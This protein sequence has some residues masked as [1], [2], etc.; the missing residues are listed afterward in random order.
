[1][2]LVSGLAGCDVRRVS[3]GMFS[4]LAVVQMEGALDGC[5]L[6]AW[7]MDIFGRNVRKLSSLDARAAAPSTSAC[8]SVE[9]ADVCVGEQDLAPAA[10]QEAS[11]GPEEAVLGTSPANVDSQ[12]ALRDSTADAGTAK[13][14]AMRVEGERAVDAAY[15]CCGADVD[16]LA[17]A[18]GEME[19]CSGGGEASEP[20]GSSAGDDS[21]LMES[22]SSPEHSHARREHASPDTP[23]AARKAELAVSAAEG[24]W[25]QRSAG[26]EGLDGGEGARAREG[27]QAAAQNLSTP[28]LKQER[29]GRGSRGVSSEK[30]VVLVLPPLARLQ[31]AK[32]VAGPCSNHAVVVYRRRLVWQMARVVWAGVLKASPEQCR[33]AWLPRETAHTSMV[34]SR[35]LQLASM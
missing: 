32:V 17:E 21:R 9:R 22:F 24:I 12:A 16:G 6:V 4:S 31:L 10:M 33:L 35:I 2:T 26:R 18:C 15:V 25:T 13:A 23:A 29:R 19:V 14:R 28:S 5:S 11:E 30:D 34:V 20:G 27:A 1:M 3:C 8:S 7:G